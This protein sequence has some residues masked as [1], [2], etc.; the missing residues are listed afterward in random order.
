MVRYLAERAGVVELAGCLV[1]VRVSSVAAFVV[2][3]CLL[4]APE[5]AWAQGA[6]ASEQPSTAS[7]RDLASGSTHRPRRVYVSMWT[8]HLKHRGIVLK[9]NWVAGLSY[10]GF[11]GATFLN[12]FG[13][14]AFTGGIQR[15][16]VVMGTPWV[17]ISLGYRLGF[18]TGYDQRL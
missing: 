4:L 13:R 2:S 9:N 15:E 1:K 8:T 10:G 7:S 17:G 6:A 3:G 18:V 5:R 11:F 14:R 16:Y 12:S